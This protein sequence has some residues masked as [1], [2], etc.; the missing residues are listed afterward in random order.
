MLLDD[1]NVIVPLFGM[2][3][4]PSDAEP[5]VDMDTAEVTLEPLIFAVELIVLDETEK[6]VCVSTSFELVLT[7]ML[8]IF[9]DPFWPEAEVIVTLTESLLPLTVNTLDV[10][11]PSSDDRVPSDT[12]L[13][14]TDSMYMSDFVVMKSKV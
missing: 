1:V 11:V 13:N 3:S 2:L 4:M 5:V 9:N 6:A 10:I 14:V 8:V 7:T 12:L